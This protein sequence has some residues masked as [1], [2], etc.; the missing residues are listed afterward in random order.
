MTFWTGF[1]TGLAKSVDQGLQKAMTKRGEELSRA[2][3]FWQTRQAQKMDAADAKDKRVDSGLKRLMDE[4][5]GDVKK[6]VLAYDKMGGDVDR[7]DSFFADVDNTRAD[8]RSYDFN[9]QFSFEGVDFDKIN[10]STLS[11]AQS[12]R[13]TEIKPLDV[14]MQDSVFGSSVFARKD[15]GEEVSSSVNKMISPR[16]RSA[17]E[18]LTSDVLANVK[19]SYTGTSRAADALTKAENAVGSIDD[20]IK[21]NIIKINSGK[22]A[23]GNSLT[24]NALK[25]AETENVKLVQAKIKMAKADAAATDTGPTSGEISKSWANALEQ[26]ETEAGFVSAK[27]GRGVAVIG[28]EGQTKIAGADVLPTYIKR[29]NEWAKT[30]AP[31]IFL[32]PNG[33]Y[34]NKDAEY[35]ASG[36][37]GLSEILAKVKKDITEKSE[38]QTG[39]TGE[40]S[41]AVKAASG[42]VG[43]ATKIT[44]DM[45]KNDPMRYITN[46]MAT[47]PNIDPQKIITALTKAGV[48][49][50]EIQ[51][52]MDRIAA[53]K[54]K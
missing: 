7:L 54:G 32:K 21:T 39:N 38:T 35:L 10:L 16:A 49:D 23:V 52:Y 19:Q 17:I 33:D 45:V 31:K 46:V 20:Q 4:F 14:Q 27:D 3:T 34:I 18:G 29:R 47:K 37:G 12:A 9:K 41:S 50:S 2:K 13:R 28:G 24:L 48:P 43:D 1:A 53:L 30:A 15:L 25:N 11:E 40:A 5:G 26:F 22:D 51:Q 8:N 6:A 44:A 36:I 42:S